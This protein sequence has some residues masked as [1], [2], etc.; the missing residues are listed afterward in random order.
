MHFHSGGDESLFG[1]PWSDILAAL[2][3]RSPPPGAIDDNDE[4]HQRGDAE[5]ISP[6]LR[7]RC[8][9]ERTRRG[10]FMPYPEINDIVF[11]KVK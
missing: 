9:Q 2:R 4:D 10:G 5:E 11:D 8:P 1:W 3:R 6:P 7:V